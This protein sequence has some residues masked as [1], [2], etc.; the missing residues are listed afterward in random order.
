MCV[1]DLNVK[2]MM[3]NHKL[4]KSVADASF[5]EFVRQLEYKCEE[6]GRTLVK[7]DR[8][9]P[10]SKTCGACGHVMDEMPLSIREWTC[11]ECGTHHD[12]DLNAAR[13]ILNEGIGALFGTVGHT[14][15][16]GD[17]A[18][19]CGETGESAETRQ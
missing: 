4:A 18:D 10:S 9:F 2:G 11:P 6:R 1:E 16:G 14:G 8:W 19:A 7:V 13:N 12:R 17:T 5:G 15:T 3:S